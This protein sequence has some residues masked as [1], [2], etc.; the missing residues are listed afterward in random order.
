MNTIKFQKSEKSRRRKAMA[1]TI[2]FHVVLFG[3]LT[4]GTEMG[5]KI[6]E[7]VKTWFQKEEP[8]KNASLVKHK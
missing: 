5:D 7:T 8:V 1:F 6:T 3:G 2:I 4:F